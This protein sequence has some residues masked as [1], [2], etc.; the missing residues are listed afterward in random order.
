MN[1]KKS[2]K[3]ESYSERI[4]SS[5]KKAKKKG[6]DIAQESIDSIEKHVEIARDIPIEGPETKNW[7]SERPK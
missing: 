5:L 7:N 3:V 6:K 1:G 4:I 2:K